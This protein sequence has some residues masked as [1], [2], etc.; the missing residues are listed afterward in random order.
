MSCILVDDKVSAD[1]G[2]GS[3]AGWTKEPTTYYFQDVCKTYIPDDNFEQALIDAGY[4]NVLDN[5]VITDNIVNVEQLLLDF[6][7]I[8]DLTGIEAFTNLK[9]L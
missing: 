6:K 2:L 9:L 4:D 5:F 7:G 8:S 1:A 3:Y